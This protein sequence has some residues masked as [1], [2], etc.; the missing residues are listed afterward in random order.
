MSER[1]DIGRL[2]IWVLFAASIS[3]LNF[4]AYASTSAVNSANESLF[5]WSFAT[6][7]AV[8]LCV[9]IAISLAISN[10]RP[11][12]RALRRPRIA[13]AAAA[14][15]GFL[16]LAASYVANLFVT[17]LGGK[18]AREQGL[19]NEHWQSGRLAPFVASVIVLTVLTPIAE[20]LFVRGLGFA[21]FQPFGQAAAMTIPALGWALM[22]GLPAAIFPLFVFG[23]GLG[24]LRQRSDS[25]IPGMIVHGLYNGLAVALAYTL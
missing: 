15:L 11:E 25:V 13:P 18:P 22:H 12:I 1:P 7:N 23:I 6:G 21:L 4:V 19:L 8:F 16:A 9:W 2:A 17:S 10:R 24:Y 3:A 14:G 20:E 5:R